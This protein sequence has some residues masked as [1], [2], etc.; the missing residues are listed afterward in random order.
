M[1][2]LAARMAAIARNVDVIIVPDWRGAE[3]VLAQIKLV[4]AMS[5]PKVEVVK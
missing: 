4:N 5:K 1:R 3:H 2:N